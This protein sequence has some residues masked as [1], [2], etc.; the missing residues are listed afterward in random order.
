MTYKR[1]EFKF[2][3]V[4]FAINLIDSG[5]YV[6]YFGVSQYLSKS[7]YKDTLPDDLSDDEKLEAAKEHL[8]SLVKRVDWGF[9]SALDDILKRIDEM[10]LI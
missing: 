5:G 3:D 9:Y 7:Y 2:N 10:K 4:T 8:R 6:I 1:T